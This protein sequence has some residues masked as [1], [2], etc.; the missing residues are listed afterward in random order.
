MPVDQIVALLK[1]PLVAATLGGVVSLVV[2]EVTASWLRV[3][4]ARV[5]AAAAA[6]PDKADDE[7]AEVEA[8]E[9]ERIAAKVEASSSPPVRVVKP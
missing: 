5:R 4:A 8:R 7:A 1:N 6:T 3:R 2:R 9:L